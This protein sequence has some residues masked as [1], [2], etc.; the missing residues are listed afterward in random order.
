MKRKVT[1]IMFATFI[2][3]AMLGKVALGSFS[4]SADEKNKNKF[5]L[6]NLSKLSKNYS[7]YSLKSLNYQ[8]KGIYNF[9]QP[10]HSAS[11]T[12]SN[13]VEFNSMIRMENGNTTYV[14]PYKYKVRV[15][16]F[17]TPT[18]PSFR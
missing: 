4:S 1:H 15:P 11:D 5:S 3:T 6:K 12:S 14:F 10:E 16:R 7:L 13:S 2:L 17:K 18:P 9:N 8:F